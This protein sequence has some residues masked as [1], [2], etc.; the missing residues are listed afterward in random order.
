MTKKEIIA[1][2]EK[3]G[4]EHDP[5]ELKDN[6]QAL[7]HTISG[8]PDET[9]PEHV[10]GESICEQKGCPNA[11]ETDDGHCSICGHPVGEHRADL[12]AECTA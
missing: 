8:K 6:L 12:L 3:A 1:A 10:Q 4:I 2:L 5:K 7:L 11:E 9:E